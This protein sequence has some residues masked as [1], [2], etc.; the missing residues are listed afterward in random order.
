M[1]KIL[2]SVTLA[3]LF[4]SFNVLAQEQSND[5][6]VLITIA[7]KGVTLSE[8][9]TI[10]RKNNSQQGAAEPKSLDEYVTLFV[11]FKLK[12]KEAEEMG[13]DTTV[14]FKNELTGY[15]KQL[16]QPYLIDKEVNEKLIKEAHERMQWDVNASHILIKLNLDAS[17][18]D[19][20]DT[21]N[22]I[23]NYRKRLVKGEQFNKVA[24]EIKKLDNKDILA[25]SLGFFTAFQM[26]YPF[27]TAAYS[28]TIGETS[29]PIRTR[30][31]YHVVKVF[32]KRPARGQIKVAHIMVKAGEKDN[33]EQKQKAKAKID[34][35][36][37]KVKAGEDFSQL[38]K[39]Y[40]D[41]INTGKK[42]GNL[43][44]FGVGPK[45]YPIEFEDASFTL[46]EIGDISEPVL[47]KY[48][49]HIIKKIDV[50]KTGSF[51]E[52]KAELKNKVARDR[53]A[54]MSRKSLIGKIKQDYGY[55]P[56]MGAVKAFYGKI[57]N[58]Y[59][60]GKWSPEKLE[61][62][63]KT[64]F[65][66]ED[67]KYGNN[68][69]EY[70]QA[71]FAKYLNDRRRRQETVEAKPYIDQ[72]FEKFVG[73]ACVK[74]EENN[75]E[76]KY[77]AF[78]ALMQEYRDGILL[79]DLM[80][81]KVWS[82]AVTDTVGLREYYEKNTNNFMWKERVDA[83]VY[84]CTNEEVAKKARTLAKKKVKKGLTEKD[85][86]EQLNVDSQLNAKIE[87][88][89]FLKGDND[90]VDK[91]EWTPGISDNM[92]KDDKIVF[93]VVNEKLAPLPKTLVEAKGLVT[94]EYQQWLENEWISELQKKYEVHVDREVLGKMKP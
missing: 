48:G 15:R 76:N 16:A 83:T 17:P 32:D 50:K 84:T 87:S 51:E 41:D 94:A 66:F 61:G 52:T 25:E 90:L 24:D 86:R 53:R 9:E 49:W 40:S 2:W 38:A 30:F 79:F 67:T 88:G 22:K 33:E 13:L 43:P 37:Q 46:K 73:E 35:I 26:V 6:P 14:A 58:S 23:M 42:G 36:Y 3:V 39:L 29:M 7:G 69:Q 1:K 12:V 89:K 34:E 81:K 57:D 8:F 63:D 11:N 19:T 59:F 5:D 54:T 4:S 27:E 65:T 47:T 93:V 71:D 62:M 56:N 82:K 28:T 72:M 91:V 55:N 80:D 18:K 10:Y 68:K 92:T 74:F 31:G 60:E 85:I 75:L 70:T 64:I 77:P 44:W 21:Y 20:L 45:G 78:R